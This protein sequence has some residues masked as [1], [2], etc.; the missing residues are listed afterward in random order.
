MLSVGVKYPYGVPHSALIFELSVLKRHA[1]PLLQQVPK[2]C[3]EYTEAYRLL[4]LLAYV[5]QIPEKEI[6]PTS[7]LR[8][9]LGGSSFRY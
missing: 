1:E 6:P 5:E 9:V 2:S 4:N 3:A 8:E 7:M